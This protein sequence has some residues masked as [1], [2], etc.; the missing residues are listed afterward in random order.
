MSASTVDPE[1][2]R[3]GEMLRASDAV[4]VF[5]G[6]GVSTASGI[7]DY[8]GPAGVWKSETPVV[9]QDFMTSAEARRRYWDQKTRAHMAFGVAVPNATH[10]ALVDLERAGKLEAV[11]TQNVDGLHA[12]AGTSPSALVELHGTVR[13]VECQTCGA[14]TD[15]EGHFAEFTHT[16]EAP[17]CSCGGYLKPATIS[18]G[19][20]LRFDDLRRA[21][22][23]AEA[24]D[25]VLA[26]G[27]TLSVTP[28]A[29]VPLVAAER[30]TPY[31]IVNRG[32]TD[33]DRFRQVTLR[34]EGD[35]GEV[36][37]LAVSLALR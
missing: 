26:L 29:A 15:P 34:I 31:V 33:H 35:V 4:L 3:L 17:T 32:P 30:G 24:A 10:R 11:V 5:T 8:R 22:E 7:P 16:G 19:Q 13:A 2:F 14:R 9:Y 1:V 20:Q 6:A 21:Q 25:L 36:V 18:F 28:A 27:S 12:A 37:P 23:A